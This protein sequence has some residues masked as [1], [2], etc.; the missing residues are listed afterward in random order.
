MNISIVFI[1]FWTF[2][3]FHVHFLRKM[4]NFRKFLGFWFDRCQIFINFCNN[5][6][7]FVI[8]NKNFIEK[9]LI[10]YAFHL[11]NHKFSF[12]G[13]VADGMYFI[14]EGTVS[15]RIE[16]ESGEVEISRLNKGS[17][18]GELALVTHRP[19]AASAY[20]EDNV[21]VACKYSFFF[22]ELS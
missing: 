12:K 9:K 3:S 11:K 2:L 13:D 1:E 6:T 16:Q 7:T 10:F 22:L 21:K 15:I 18:F 14:E 19:R 20:A 17:Y 4:S 8:F 5:F